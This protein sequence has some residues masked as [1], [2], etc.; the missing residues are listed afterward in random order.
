M[1]TDRILEQMPEYKGIDQQLRKLSQ[2]W[3][4]ELERMQ[5][6][7]EELKQ[8]FA[9]REILYTDEVR[10]QKQADIRQQV[11]QRE[12]YMEQKFGAEGEYFLQQKALLEPI[13]R[14][15]FEA[16]NTV[17][18]RNGYDFVFDRAGDTS[19]LYFQQEWNLNDEVLIEL[20]ISTSE[21]EVSN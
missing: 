8:D 4:N 20:G 5:N 16:I 21:N 12:Q 10:K 11:R 6:E 15:V 18:D 1:N 3:K 13:Q 14:K 2:E 7:I 19:M 9:D 17:A